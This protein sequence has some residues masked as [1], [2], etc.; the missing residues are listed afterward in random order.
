MSANTESMLPDRLHCTSHVEIEREPQYEEEWFNGAE[1][2]TIRFNKI[3]WNENVCALSAC[4]SE[5]QMQLY[6]ITGKSAPHLSLTKA[7]EQKWAALGL[8]VRK[9]MRATDGL[10]SG[11]ALLQYVDDLLI[12]ARDE[13][14]CVADIVTL[15][16]HLAREGHKVSLTKLQFVKQEITFLGH[17][18]TPN[19]K[20]I[21]E[22]RIK[23]IKDV[24]K[25]I[26]KKQLL[27][28]LGMCAYC[29]TFIPN[30][31]FLE[32]PLRA[33]TTG[34][35]LRSCD[36][37]ERPFTQMVDAVSMIL[38]EQRT[39]HLST[40]RWL[41][42]HTIL[43]D[44][45]NVTVK[46]CTS[47]NPATLLPTEEDGEEHHCCLSVLEQVCTPRPDL[48]DTPLENCDNVLFVDG[49]ASKDPQT[50]LNKVGFAV[51]TEF[52][53]VKSGK[54]PSNY[55][56]QGAELV[57]LTEA[58]NL[59]ADKCVT[60]YTDSR[61]AFGVT[62]DFGALWKHR[63]FLKSDGHPILNASLVSKLLEAIL[64]PDKVAICK[65]AAH[66]NDK[67]FIST[68]N[69]RADA[70]AKA[71]AAQKTKE[72]TCALVSVT[73]PD[74]SPCLQSMQTFST[75]AEKQQWRS[76][77]CSLQGGCMDEC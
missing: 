61:Y 40:A 14:T 1:N 46:R 2:E 43:L 66:T 13:V 56:A 37:I 20:A 25:P 32:K 3:F 9:C 28:F 73:N 68:G 18:I 76:S 52:E 67:S 42:Y 38:Q 27:S 70:A 60:I 58:C 22:K 47:L 71:A 33:L 59:M 53:V 62:H 15:L 17:T 30:Y 8:F 12:C 69:A 34:K 7:T 65:C 10:K 57:A 49:S 5:K 39:S 77:G 41:R 64:L 4:L 21:S 11:T 44:M 51:T 75:G 19:S 50:G 45:P 35:G 63:N 54:L 26:T 24:P 31:A 74:I 23:A 72:T 55:S 16:N 6:L 48:L 36:K 29:R